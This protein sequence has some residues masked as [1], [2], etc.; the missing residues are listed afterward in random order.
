MPSR[1]KQPSPLTPD[2]LKALPISIGEARKLLG[3]SASSMSDEDVAQEIL[4]ASELARTT[5]RTLYLQK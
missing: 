1:N 3:S 2:L 5:L 4:R